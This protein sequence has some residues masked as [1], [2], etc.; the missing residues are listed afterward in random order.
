MTAVVTRKSLFTI[1][2]LLAQLSILSVREGD[3]FA[4]LPPA[5]ASPEASIPSAKLAAAGLSQLSLA[6]ARV[7]SS[8]L[9]STCAV[10]FD[11]AEEL[12]E[13][14]RSDWHQNNVR[15]RSQNRST[16]DEH[17]FLTKPPT[18]STAASS[19]SSNQ[20]NS[21]EPASASDDPDDD[22]DEKQALSDEEE[23]AVTLAGAPRVSFSTAS[24]HVLIWKS[25]L[26]HPRLPWSTSPFTVRAVHY[27]TALRDLSSLSRIGVF[28][29]MG[30]R[31]AGGLFTGIE[32]SQHRTFARYTVRAKQGGSQTA[33][34]SANSGHQAKSIGSS[35]RRKEA[36]RFREEVHEVMAEW[37]D[38]L[39]SCQRIFL[40]APSYNRNIFYRPAIT[41]IRRPNE[42]TPGSDGS[43]G[44]S[45]GGGG[46]SVVELDVSWDKADVRIRSI[47]FS[48]YRP[49]FA[50]VQR[51]HK[52]LTTVEFVD[53]TPGDDDE[54]ALQ[55]ADTDAQ[56]AQ[57]DGRKDAE[58][59]PA[60]DV[61]SRAEPDSVL[62]AIERDD[63]PTLQQLLASGYKRPV[64]AGGAKAM[65]PAVYYAAT[66]QR[67]DLLTWLIAED[68]G[69]QDVDEQCV[70][71][72]STAST[73]CWTALHFA[74]HH[75]LPQL[76][77]HLLSLHAS[78][79][80][81][82]SRGLTAYNSCPAGDDGRDI[83][84][85]IRQWAAD[86]GADS[87]WEW[88]E[89]GFQ[90]AAKRSAEEDEERK[91]V[92]KEKEKAKKA[93]AKLKQKERREEE[94]KEKHSEEQQRAQ[95]AARDTEQRAKK[96]ADAKAA[97]AMEQAWVAREKQLA[98]LSDREKRAMAAERRINA[99]K[100]GTAGAAGG[101]VEKCALPSCGRSL[102][103]VPF[104]R[105]HF[106]YDTLLCLQQH[107]AELDKVSAVR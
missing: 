54:R 11:T 47:P 100:G 1:Q 49:T 72:T 16:I 102:V 42:P 48:V 99:L 63:L 53:R 10:A 31:F 97:L 6:N 50:E 36:V 25:L 57:Q 94:A 69:R 104:E 77:L 17:T 20:S 22:D 39:A 84:A 3:N 74:C 101:T 95:Q 15:L 89:A 55:V 12:R 34:D 98:G 68:G 61:V 24:Q 40:F 71:T 83:R 43:S 46:S 105:L 21:S 19:S 26:T 30:G 35:I 62:E 8:F 5:A 92:L 4:L 58:E 52:L 18:T 41:K 76:A 67:L 91:R 38:E 80:V 87:G 107:R 44:G 88:K 56:E 33:N 65:V 60:G 45:G 79:L 81:R 7:T 23:D 103:R 13:H 86:E 90:P 96:E 2:P 27:H 66:L 93:K 70:T 64:P 106:K 82:D 85:A 75:N 29:C 78:P 28:L 59:V 14:A 73:V 51:V 9:C 37:R 32:C